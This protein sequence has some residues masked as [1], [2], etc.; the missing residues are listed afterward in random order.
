MRLQV[1]LAASST[2]SLEEW[3]TVAADSAAQLVSTERGCLMARM[4]WEYDCVI[5]PNAFEELLGEPK[6]ALK[7]KY[8]EDVRKALYEVSMALYTGPS[9][10]T[11]EDLVFE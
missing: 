10:F 6:P 4:L 7:V 3:A 1:E 11:D 2:P 9:L 5:S 8:P